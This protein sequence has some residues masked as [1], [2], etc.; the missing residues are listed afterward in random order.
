MFIS[1]EFADQPWAIGKLFMTR[2]ADPVIGG[3]DHHYQR[4]APEDPE[5]RADAQRGLR[6]FVVGTDGKT[7][8]RLLAAIEPRRSNPTDADAFGVLKLILHAN[9]YEWSFLP[10]AG[11]TFTDSGHGT[12]H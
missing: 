3:H 11:K 10:E 2:P 4:F 6:E 1:V 12:C 5:G 7:R 9:S 8:H